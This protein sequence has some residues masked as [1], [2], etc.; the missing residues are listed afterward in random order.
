[1]PYRTFA[2][3]PLLRVILPFLA[4]ILCFS[5][6]E[7]AASELW[8][9]YVGTL[10]LAFIVHT[11][12][13]LPYPPLVFLL[14][15]VTVF[16]GAGAWTRLHLLPEQH[17]HYSAF[18][19]DYLC[20]HIWQPVE[21]KENSY[22]TIVR[23]DSL[24]DSKRQIRKADGKLLLYLQKD[25]TRHALAIGDK[26]LLPAKF[27]P[28]EG[29]KNPGQFNYKDYIAGKQIYYQAYVRSGELVRICP[30]ERYALKRWSQ[31][32]SVSVQ[33][34]LFRFIPNRDAA[35]LADG[36]LLG[37]R[38]DIEAGL[39]DAFAYT[40]I[41]HILSVS[42]LH[43]GIVYALLALLL[44][45]V[46]DRNR[47]IRIIKFLVI[48]ACIWLFALVT[49]MGA[50]VVRAAILFSLLH[51]GRLSREQTHPINLLGGAALIQLFIDP[52]QVYDI[53]FQLSYLAMLG[54]FLLAKPIYA[55]YYH[56]NKLVD[57]TWQLWSASLG[58]QLF[59]LPLSLFYFG[60]FPTWFLLANI[61]AIPLSTLILWLSLALIPMQGV[62][63]LGTVL[64]KAIGFLGWFFTKLTLFIA[65]LPLGQVSGLKVNALQA[66]LIFIAAGLFAVFII[67]KKYEA[68]I[69]ALIIGLITTGISIY[70]TGKLWSSSRIILYTIPK[71][72]VIGWSNGDRQVLCLRD[73]LSKKQFDFCIRGSQR[74]YHIRDQRVLFLD[75]PVQIPGI[76]FKDNL[77]IVDGQSFFFLDKTNSRFQ[78][79]LPL[80][81][82]HLLISG[83]VYLDMD[84]LKKHYRFGRL[85]LCSDNDNR[86]LRIYR[87][88]LDKAGIP[89]TD[90]SRQAFEIGL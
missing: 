68:L 84:A 83:N 23:I 28:I 54:L 20:G 72:T 66:V 81:V 38:A 73:T 60:N 43:V 21:E 65:G 89:Y 61:F 57:W 19:A 40:G 31:D 74:L 30:G 50:A 86:H 4:G 53:G 15:Q 27:Q 49:G 5:H 48:L 62:P 10:I 37:H 25:S 35:A 3:L 47:I 64:G 45:V 1:M 69:L 39:Y 12:V 71:I 11:R 59:T 79:G 55:L 13:R 6:W 34:V 32:L 14:F 7:I 29:P 41:L 78:F 36:I 8:I 17:E 63:V 42:G 90:L 18:Q 2:D 67:R 75:K 46:P 16:L 26:I 87:K 56:P 77:L 76:S 80:Q 51:Y 52:L 33:R 24:I 88:L 85:Y 44:K 82:D 9:A 70:D 22:K 58:A